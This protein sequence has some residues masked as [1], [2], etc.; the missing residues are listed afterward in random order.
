MLDSIP[1]AVRRLLPP[2]VL[3]L[4]ALSSLVVAIQLILLVPELPLL[5]ASFFGAA[6]LQGVGAWGLYQQRFWARGFGVGALL[7]SGIGVGIW[8]TPTGI[9][10]SATLLSILLLVLGD[11]PGR[12]ERRAAFLEQRKLDR[13]GAN[14]LFWVSLA[15]GVALPSMLGSSLSVTL[16]LE[17]PIPFGIAVALGLL[18]FFGLTR[19]ASWCW[20][21]IVGA[22]V[23]LVVA[24]V[25]SVYDGYALSGAW[26]ALLAAVVASAALPI[27][28]PVVRALRG[29]R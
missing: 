20:F 2:I 15:L 28:G 8:L 18:G 22:A 5:G 7:S 17:A 16:W 19:L 9:A 25:F 23:A 24:V 26:A 27:T 13:R 6:A 3:G 21:A 14:R 1:P 11:A 10:M 12:Y 4:A 29:P